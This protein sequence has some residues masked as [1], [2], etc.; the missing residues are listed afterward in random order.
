[1]NNEYYDENYEYYNKLRPTVYNA[2]Y[3]IS[4]LKGRSIYTMSSKRTSDFD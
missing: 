1:M 3:E 2:Q 4:S